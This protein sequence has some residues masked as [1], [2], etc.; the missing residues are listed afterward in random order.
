MGCG[1]PRAAPPGGGTGRCGG[2]PRR[3]RPAD[4]PPAGAT[5][6]LEERAAGCHYR[7]I[8]PGSRSHGERRSRRRTDALPWRT[9][10]EKASAGGGAANARPRPRLTRGPYGPRRRQ[11]STTPQGHRS[12]SSAPRPLPPQ[13]LITKHPLRSDSAAA[14]GLLGNVVQSSARAAG[15]CLT[16]NYHSQ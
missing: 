5:E 12:C 4:L 2:G 9:S 3:V 13:Q 14:R 6:S 1:C 11:K 7:L 8:A 16:M 10:R 15:L